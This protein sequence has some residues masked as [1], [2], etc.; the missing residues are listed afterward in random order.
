MP[1][2]QGVSLAFL[3]VTDAG[4]ATLNRVT[5]LERLNLRHTAIS[6]ELITDL[7]NEKSHSLRRLNLS[8]TV[9]DDM[10]FADFSDQS[11]LQELSVIDTG[12]TDA[13]CR[14]IA[15]CEWLDSLRLDLTD[16]TDEGVRYLEICGHLLNLDLF[17]TRVTDTCLIWLSDSKIEHLGLG[18]TAVT[19]AGM[20]VLTEFPALRSLDLQATGITDRGLR[21]LSEALYLERL[22]LENT[23]ISNAGLVFLLNL[24]LESLSLNLG[25][26]DM[27]LTTL[28][29]HK[30]LL[31]LATWNTNVTS[32]KP[33]SQLSRLQV[34]LVD[35]SA[36]DLSPLK[37]LRQLKVLLL[38]GHGV[39]PIEVA[40]L[41][42]S[43]PRFL[44]VRYERLPHTKTRFGNF[45][46]YAKTRS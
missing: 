37:M 23:R 17:K 32:W 26:D 33:I 35:N 13:A 27:G 29:H 24:P 40:S 44:A 15:Q 3:D 42:L 22:Y 41:R 5:W 28:S 6:N 7:V 19:D 39:S 31:N 20:P 11:Q 1:Q 18:Y 30:K 25:I 10:A 14:H 46:T 36:T 8:N 38:S 45:G 9:V 16:I 12:I 34:L 43:L 2:L 4:L 21:F